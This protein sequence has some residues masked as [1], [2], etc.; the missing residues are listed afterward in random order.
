MIIVNGST[1]S[2]GGSLD[3]HTDTRSVFAEN[4]T[5]G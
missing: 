1:D 5:G 3:L 2:K 4:I